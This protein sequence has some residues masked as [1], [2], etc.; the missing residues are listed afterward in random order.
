MK[1]ATA[2]LPVAALVLGLLSLP[3]TSLAE[4]LPPG[5]FRAEVYRP[6]DGWELPGDTPNVLVQLAA[7]APTHLPDVVRIEWEWKSGNSWLP[8]YETTH[9]WHAFPIEQTA[10]LFTAGAGP[11]RVRVWT[12]G[13]IAPGEG[14]RD[15]ESEPSSWHSFT[16]GSPPLEATAVTR[17]AT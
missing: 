3:T 4:D 8:L 17:L 9:Q 14:L 15:W 16:I 5:A 2:L 7:S 12:R 13:R 10:A 11:Y 1:L 6:G